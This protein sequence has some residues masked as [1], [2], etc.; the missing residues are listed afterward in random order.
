MTMIAGHT[1]P[2]DITM[3]RISERLVK[4]LLPAGSL[5]TALASATPV[6]AQQV[7]A[8]QAPAAWIA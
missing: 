1:I 3:S 4:A 2:E 8:G 6:G 5:F 7:S